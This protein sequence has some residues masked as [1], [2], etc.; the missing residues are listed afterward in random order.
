MAAS[1]RRVPSSASSARAPTRSPPRRTFTSGSVWPPIPTAT[2]IRSACCP[3]P[4]RNPSPRRHPSPSLSPS[5]RR[6]SRS[7]SSLT[8]RS[9]SSPFHAR[10][11]RRRSRRSSPSLSLSRSRRWSLRSHPG[12]RSRLRS[13]RRSRGRQPRLVRPGARWYRRPPT[14]RRRL[15]PL[16]RRPASLRAHG[17]P[18]ALDAAPPGLRRSL[19]PAG[20]TR[21]RR[22]SAS[23]RR[24]GAP[25][26]LFAPPWH[27]SRRRTARHRAATRS[28]S[29][30]R[31]SRLPHSSPRR[32]GASL[33]LS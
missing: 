25:G 24:R 12:R 15:A 20:R 4:H 31:G 19:Q 18:R 2:S 28:H 16:A 26:T 7:R 23:H 17:L 13:S 30:S 11:R 14:S 33:R 3:P 29:G 27:R 22:S 21:L 8:S 5:R 9:P 6:S 1:S 10:L 32:S